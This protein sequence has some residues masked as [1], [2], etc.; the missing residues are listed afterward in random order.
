[1]LISYQKA[2]LATIPKDDKPKE[3]P[4][5]EAYYAITPLRD[6]DWR[7]TKPIKIR[8]FKP[9]Y[10]LTMALENTTISELI[11]MDNTYLDRLTLR[12]QLIAD[13]GAHVVAAI[14]T[15]KPAVDEF[16]KW[17]TG[18]YL[19]RR[20]P[21]IY[22]HALQP[23]TGHAYLH[24]LAT[25]EA[26]PLQPPTSVTDALRTLGSHV[27]TEFLFLRPSPDPKDEGRYRLEG[28]ANCSPSGF[29]TLAKLGL[30][31]ADIHT[32]VPGYAQK[33]ERSMDRFFAALP[34]GKIVKRH[35][36][37][38]T[39]NRKLFSLGG[40][41]L[42]DGEEVKPLTKEEVDIDQC[43]LRCERQTLHRLRDND[44]T[45]VFAFKTYQYPLQDVKEEGSGEELAQAVEGLSKGSVPRMA[46]YKRQVV[47]G[48]VVKEYLRARD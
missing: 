16:Y 19:P 40:N 34:V 22:S 33:L 3:Q 29:D 14:S 1:M 15:V 38:V 48:E 26:I 7:E 27:D 31:L 13:H 9:K 21:T 10:H 41:H 44:D 24:N 28:F 2:V 8:P 45:L 42:Y 5:K 43:V 37:S 18:V 35:N 46:F 6:F 20:F 47:W 32:P 12:R 25:G 4:D 23:E 11:E 36:W 17:M 39:M 30:R